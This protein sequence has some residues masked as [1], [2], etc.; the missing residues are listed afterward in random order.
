MTVLNRLVYVKHA[1]VTHPIQLDIS[2]SAINFKKSISE[3]TGVPAGE[4]IVLAF[5]N[6]ASLFCG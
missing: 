2:S 4:F 5:M 1:G 3:K 6:G